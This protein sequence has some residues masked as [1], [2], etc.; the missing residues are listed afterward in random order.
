MPNTYNYV[1]ALTYVDFDK[2]NKD[3]MYFQNKSEKETYFD[4]STLFDASNTNEINFEKKN[5]NY[6]DV[7]ISLNGNDEIN[8]EFGYNYL[9]IKE[10]STSEYFFYFIEKHNYLNN[11]RMNL[12]CSLDIFTTYF[13]KLIFEGTINRATLREFIKDDN[14]DIIYDTQ[15][16]THVFAVDD[17]YQGKKFLQNDKCLQPHVFT[18]VDSA[19]L[20]QWM[21][22]N[23]EAWQYIY[24]DK[25]HT[26][27]YDSTSYRTTDD[28]MSKG[29]FTGYGV[30]AMPIYKTTH[31]MY[32]R[33]RDVSD[34][35][36]PVQYSIQL[37]EHAIDY[38]RDSNN[39]NAYIYSSKIS[40]QPPF[41]PLLS[42]SD[43]HNFNCSIELNG[44]NLWF[45][46]GDVSG[47][48]L[49]RL[50]Q[51]YVK[52]FITHKVSG[53]YFIGMLEVTYQTNRFYNNN[54]SS[55]VDD[56]IQTRMTKTKYLSGSKEFWKYPNSTSLKNIELRLTYNGQ[57]YTT[58]PSKIDTGDAVIEMLETLSPD[59]SKTYIRWKHTGYYAFRSYNS[60]TLTGGI[61][62]DDT[63]ISLAT[64]ELQNVLAN[65]KNFFY[66]KRVNIGANSLLN[67]ATNTAKM[68]VLGTAKT[69]AKEQLNEVNF[70][71]EVDNIENA[72]SHLEKASGNALFNILTKDYGI[73]LEIWMMTQEDLT[74]IAMYYNRYGVL[75]NTVGTTHEIIKKHKYFDYTEFEAFYIHG[76]VNITN[77][78]KDEFIRKLKRGVRFWYDKTTMYNYTLYN[79]ERALE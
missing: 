33:F 19:T 11:G 6:I 65:S 13:D 26:Y 7:T 39:D 15:A 10:L 73:H 40:K 51:N 23:I 25:N 67:L 28:F 5:L 57:E 56:Y 34:P 43:T 3:V 49:T 32:V 68:D 8:N 35:N 52:T 4:L 75:T 17:T 71:F 18:Y 16:Y 77:E 48:E 45:N 60:K 78:I 21:E 55:F 37:T 50:L 44:S 58:S 59:I 24:V 72:P 42:N 29:I 1:Y 36:N 69:L 46:F 53:S 9:I 62:S 63:S 14:N 27:K 30:L 41:T 74:N 47:G 61:F 12:K 22:E 66:Q 20:D 38:F 76:S 31:L 79:Y 70:G 64:S 54:V 2:E